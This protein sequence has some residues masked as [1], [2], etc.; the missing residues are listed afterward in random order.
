MKIISLDIG[1]KRIG[2][3]SC[4]ALEIAA[5]PHSMV[6]A[7]KTA[8]AEIAKLVQRE[9]AEMV[10]IGLATS[11][12][13]VERE[14]CQRARMFKK[15]LEALIEVPIDFYDERFTSKIAEQSL[16]QS[17]MRRENRKEH[18]DAVAAAIILRGYLDYRQ[19]CKN[20]ETREL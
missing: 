11:F 19:N 2:V 16:I 18:I 14:A 5:S 7:G 20:K 8:A 4:D 3:A 12:D 10:V 17:G 1:K 13:G 15:E 9:G 6:K